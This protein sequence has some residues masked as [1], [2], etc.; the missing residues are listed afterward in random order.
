[1]ASFEHK[2][3][4]LNEWMG[5]RVLTTE[6]EERIKNFYSVRFPT[7]KIF[8]E[9][10]ILEDL[11][12]SL[13]KETLIEL[14]RD[15]VCSVPLF[16]IC[17]P[18]TQREICYCL[19][20]VWKS[21]DL[22][23][24]TEGQ[25]PTSLYIVRFGVV[26]L[27]ADG[28][29]L[30]QASRGEMFGENAL[31]GLS[32]S[33]LRTRTA[34]ARTMVELCELSQENLSRLLVEL[35]DLFGKMKQMVNGYLQYLEIAS[36]NKVPIIKKDYLCVN[37]KVLAEDYEM[38]TRQK[39]D[40]ESKRDPPWQGGG[41]R[42][43]LSINIAS[44]TGPDPKQQEQEQVYVFRV[45]W[46]G[47]GRYPR[48][49]DEGPVVYHGG[50]HS[51][52]NLVV[53]HQCLVLN[54]RHDDAQ[55]EAMP[56]V[57]ISMWK[58]SKGSK[59][60]AMRSGRQFEKSA[61]VVPVAGAG[62]AGV[63]KPLIKGVERQPLVA[64]EGTHHVLDHS[65]DFDMFVSS[66]RNITCKGFRRDSANPQWEKYAA[67]SI[68]IKDL[69]S[70]RS[71]VLSPNYWN[72]TLNGKSGLANATVS[73]ATSCI[74][75]IP[76]T[77]TWRSVMSNLHTNAGSTGSKFFENFTAKLIHAMRASANRHQLFV[78]WE[79]KQHKNRLL[80]V[81]KL[82]DPYEVPQKEAGVFS[83]APLGSGRRA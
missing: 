73:I 65:T 66:V 32:K 34:V 46:P 55:W 76:P 79:R 69:I 49:E 60:Q 83:R 50:T 25:V 67:C 61:K 39:L 44:F 4:E 26:D 19:Q 63:K 62:G 45:E 71:S 30:T 72:E 29:F 64:L 38:E 6:L 9:S 1:V 54:V 10:C 75:R 41:L 82:V 81:S 15:I 3:E 77:S 20:V 17:T 21:A 5:A 52:S 68:R 8:N 56:N 33:G 18:H 14:Y 51:D 12:T 7:S 2:M 47:Y 78:L 40:R 48:V 37:W 31:L 16:S 36:E 24:T 11:P 42:T 80:K 13:R 70:K 58:F 57:E 28:E 23:I 43:Q 27:Y 22:A 74:R 59:L 53:L 35:E